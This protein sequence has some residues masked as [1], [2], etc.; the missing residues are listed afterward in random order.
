[1]KND[2]YF[3]GKALFFLEIFKFLYFPLPLLFPLLVIA[4]FIG[5]NHLRQ[6]LK[7][8]MSSFSERGIQ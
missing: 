5:E 3:Y 4:T 2:F 7:F 8:I 1:M 6:I